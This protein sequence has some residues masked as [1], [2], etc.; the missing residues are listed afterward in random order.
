[1]E[2][3][4][5]RHRWTLFCER[6]NECGIDY[7]FGYFQALLRFFSQRT[8]LIPIKDTGKALVSYSRMKYIPPFHP[9]SVGAEAQ[10]TEGGAIV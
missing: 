3:F 2:V 4:H 1:M 10:V 7:T 9:I 8:A 6:G 5:D